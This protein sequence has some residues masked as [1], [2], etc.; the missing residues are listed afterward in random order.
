MVLFE[1]TV[2]DC[3]I[4]DGDSRWRAIISQKISEPL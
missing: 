1:V 4:G 3:C 2:K